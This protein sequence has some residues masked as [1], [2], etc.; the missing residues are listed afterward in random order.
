MSSGSASNAAPTANQ[1]PTETSLID[2]SLN[3]LNPGSY[4]DLHK[5]TKGRL[6]LILLKLLNFC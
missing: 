1:A 2:P 5:K 4:E 3:T 6:L